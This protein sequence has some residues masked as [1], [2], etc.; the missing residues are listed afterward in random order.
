MEGIEMRALM[1]AAAGIV[2]ALTSGCASV[3]TNRYLQAQNPARLE[4]LA[5]G[6]EITGASLGLDLL[7]LEQVVA[8]PWMTAGA[9]VVDAA[10][11]YGVYKLGED[12]GGWGSGG[13][14]EGSR[15]GD[16]L[17]DGNTGAQASINVQGN[18]NTVIVQIVQPGGSNTGG[19]Q[20]ISA[21]GSGSNSDY[22]TDRGGE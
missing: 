11:V 10:M 20:P 14:G 3:A 1:M 8:H 15:G 13:S 5:S 4:L 9:A 6:G 22:G 12:Q 16:Q 18:D 19:D 21:P 17:R 2:A 7:S